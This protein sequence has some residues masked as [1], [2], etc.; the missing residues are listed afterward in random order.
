MTSSRSWF[1]NLHTV[2]TNTTR[3]SNLS[4]NVRPA[5]RSMP[6]RG[7]SKPRVIKP[8]TLLLP[9][10]QVPNPDLHQL[11]LTIRPAER[12]CLSPLCQLPSADTGQFRYSSFAMKPQLLLV[13]HGQKMVIA[14]PALYS[15]GRRQLH[16]A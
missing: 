4:L 7:S 9:T 10:L 3:C 1:L 5:S 2:V 6:S 11:Q 13:L 14:S 8:R 12:F 16:H 15:H